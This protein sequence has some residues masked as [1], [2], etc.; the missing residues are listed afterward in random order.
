MHNHI[1]SFNDTSI[2]D[3]TKEDKKPKMVMKTKGKYD[4]PKKLMEMAYSA[5][6]DSEFW[7]YVSDTDNEDIMSTHNYEEYKANFR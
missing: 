7:D 5:S 2:S 1:R 4:N 6:D 3:W